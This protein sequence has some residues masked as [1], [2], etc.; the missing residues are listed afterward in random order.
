MLWWKWD[1]GIQLNLSYEGC[2]P[3]IGRQGALCGNVQYASCSENF[4]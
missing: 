4:I 1:K 3:I 2:Y